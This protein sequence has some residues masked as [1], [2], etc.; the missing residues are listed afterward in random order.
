MAT[1]TMDKHSSSALRVRKHRESMVKNGFKRIQK[2]VFDI[3]SISIQEQMKAD[4]ANYTITQEEKE[5][6]TFAT[7]QLG[8]LEGWQ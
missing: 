6:N 7:E 3:E 8:N 1:L 4:L 5:W 2:W